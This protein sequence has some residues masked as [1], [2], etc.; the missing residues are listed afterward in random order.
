MEYLKPQSP[1]SIGGKYIYP[2]TTS[3]QIINGNGERIK[4]IADTNEICYLYS[5][6]F[7]ISSWNGEGPYTQSATLTAVDGGGQVTA[8][9]TL[10][11]CVGID[12]TLPQATK[13]A[14]KNAASNI[15]NAEKILGNNTISVS[16]TNKPNVDVELYFLIKEGIGT[17]IP[18]LNPVENSTKV[19]KLWE[20]PNPTASFASQKVSLDLSVY[21]AVIV[22]CVYSTSNQGYSKSE[23]VFPEKSVSVQIFSFYD[24]LPGAVRQVIMDSD[25]V[26]FSDS[27][28][29][30][31]DNGNYIMENGTNLPVS[32][33]GVQF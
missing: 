2:L 26:T 33:Y 29:Y 30:K 3:D 31:W 7:S 13:D 10:L 6:V 19:D 25:G 18:T 27:Y 23:I 28:W 15:T 9:S 5:A 24:R 12:S 1:I 16:L 17:S 14:M 11:A 22:T 20:N 8:Q 21:D 4:N 32:I